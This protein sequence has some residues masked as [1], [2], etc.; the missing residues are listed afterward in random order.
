MTDWGGSAVSHMETHTFLFICETEV[1]P[2]LLAMKTAAGGPVDGS[3]QG[4]EGLSERE[5]RWNEDLRLWSGSCSWRDSSIDYSGDKLWNTQTESVRKAR[6][7]AACTYTIEFNSSGT[8]ERLYIQR[9]PPY[10]VSRSC[11]MCGVYI[12]WCP[13]AGQVQRKGIFRK[14]KVKRSG[15]MI[16]H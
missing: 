5:E 11:R 6:A 2:G 14:L 12:K 3:G 9:H 16:T 7:S 4:S 8:H 15:C 1:L 10:Y 13:V